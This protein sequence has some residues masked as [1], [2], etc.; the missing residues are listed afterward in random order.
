MLSG[1]L[2]INKPKG[3]TSNRIVLNLKKKLNIGKIGHTGILDFSAEGLLVVLIG[4]AT[5]LTEYLQKLDK[6]YI[7]IGKL[8]EHKETYDISGKTISRKE[9]FRKYTTIEKAVKQFIGE[10]DQLPPPYSSKKIKG[11]RAYKLAK[12]G[13]D[14][15]L[16]PV[17]IKIYN[18]E[19][20]EI[21]LPFFKIKVNCSSGT[22]IRSLIKDIGDRL[23]C[24][25]Y[26]HTLKRTKIGDLSVEN[27]IDYQTIM[28]MP[29]EKILEKLLP[30]EKALTFM[31]TIHLE[32]EDIQ[33]FS[34]GKHIPLINSN[35]SGL[36][37]VFNK[38]NQLIGIGYLKNNVLKPEKVFRR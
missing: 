38:S 27:A 4:K 28:E 16:K 10:Y 7:A 13:I 26:M 5:R 34:Y 24:G 8:G 14:P 31:P 35:K 3:I 12:K 1:I 19:I 18:I 30:M 20:Q 33:S 22:Y 6:E 15:Q 9:C 21:A 25:A 17:K 37:K 36:V 23:N 11:V 29:K 32:E 2:L